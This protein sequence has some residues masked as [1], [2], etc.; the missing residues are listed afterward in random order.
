VVQ[1]KTG[2]KLWI[3][4]TTS[5][6][7]V[8]AQTPR[9]GPTICAWGRGKPTS[10]RGA[11]DLIWAVRVQIGAEAWDI[12]SLRYNAAAE[13]GAAGCSDELIQSVTGHSTT[14]MVVKYAGSARQIARATEAQGRRK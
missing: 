8:L 7:A 4:F 3:P 12:H 2:A 13:L 14:A 1:R 5:L 10:Y 11:A 9:I 6:A